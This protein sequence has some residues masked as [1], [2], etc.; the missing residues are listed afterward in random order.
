VVRNDPERDEEAW[1]S[2]V[3]NFGDR[4]ELD[5]PMPPEPVLPD[6]ALAIPVRAVPED[7]A[8]ADDVD[9][10]DRFVPPDPPLPPRPSR[11]RQLAWIGLFGAPLLLLVLLLLDVGIPSLLAYAL[12]VGFIGG[13]GY[14]VFHLPRN[15]DDPFDDGAR[16]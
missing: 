1:R 7:P 11:D 6:P 3:E 10:G 12:V 9:E 5:E 8:G 15:P 13:F 14:L 16:L 4:A 2:I